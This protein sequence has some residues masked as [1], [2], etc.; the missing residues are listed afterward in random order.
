MKL[1]FAARRAK[2]RINCISESS[3]TEPEFKKATT[4]ELS[5]ENEQ[6]EPAS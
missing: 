6:S 5:S 4:A 3:L 2:Q 1:H